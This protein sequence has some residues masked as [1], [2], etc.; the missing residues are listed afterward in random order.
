[1]GFVRVVVAAIACLLA[2]PATVLAV[3]QSDT[4]AVDL[5]VF[6]GRGCPHCARALVW[7]DDLLGRRPELRVEVL[8]VVEDPRALEELALLVRERGL[9]GGVTVPTFVVRGEDVHVGFGEAETTGR[10]LEGLLVERGAAGPIIDSVAVRPGDTSV[11][12]SLPL[13]GTV[14]LGEVG[15]PAFTIALGLV[16]GFNPCAMWVLLFLISMLMHV[17]SRRRMVMVGGVFVL[18]SGM[19]YYAFMAAWLNAFSFSAW[20][21]GFR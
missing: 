2:T 5:R 15:L 16:D 6:T 8:D 9:G 1:M 7:V 17:P 4:M 21:A 19:V 11:I 13:F 20:P 14:S 10:M 12:V 3:Q 18:V